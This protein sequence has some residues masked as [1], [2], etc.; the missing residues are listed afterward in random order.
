MKR[1]FLNRSNSGSPPPVD[2][3]LDTVRPIGR[4]AR[5]PPTSVVGA[6]VAGGLVDQPRAAISLPASAALANAVTAP[7]PAVSTL[8]STGK[9]R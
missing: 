4:A 9:R 2:T 6:T 8:E 3:R 5:P 7:L 1:P